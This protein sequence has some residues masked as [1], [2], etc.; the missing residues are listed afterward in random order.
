WNFYHSRP[1]VFPPHSPAVHLTSYSVFAKAPTLTP[2]SPF[3][4]SHSGLSS[5]VRG[6]NDLTRGKATISQLHPITTLHNV[7]ASVGHNL[8]DLPSSDKAEHHVAAPGGTCSRHSPCQPL[9]TCAPCFEQLNP[10]EDKCSMYDGQFGACCPPSPSPS[11]PNRGVFAAPHFFVKTPDFTLYQLNEAAKAGL[12]EVAERDKLERTLQARDIVVRN[13]RTPEYRHLQFFKT[14]P[15]AMRFGR[16]AITVERSTNFLMIRYDLTPLQASFGLRQFSLRDTIL[17]DTCPEQPFC[18]GKEEYYRTID[19]SCNNPNNPTWGQAKTALQRILPAH[20]DDGV[21]EPRGRRSPRQLPSA[22]LVS[23]SNVADVDSPDPELTL[24]VMQFGQ[25]IDHDL[26]HVPIFRFGNESGIE[27]CND[28]GFVDPALTH[29]SCFAIEIPSDDPFFS[30]F[31]RRC[32][33]FVR[34]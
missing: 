28:R 30:R 11:A 15:R 19:G 18:G 6:Q 34:S 20:Y 21:Y 7:P 14:S 31:G 5:F 25:F 13:P 32:M 17:S 29:P 33:N 16:A 3:A 10:H 23:I 22:R 9:V 4:H 24:S 26:T 1:V 12:W 2:T 27:C 8:L